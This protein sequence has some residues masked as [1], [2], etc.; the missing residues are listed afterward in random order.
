M[1]YHVKNPDRFRLIFG[2]FFLK[3]FN[4]AIRLNDHHYFLCL[5]VRF[6]N[7]TVFVFGEHPTKRGRCALMT[8]NANREETLI[9]ETDFRVLCPTVCINGEYIRLVIRSFLM[10]GFAT[11]T[12][13]PEQNISSMNTVSK[14]STVLTSLRMC[15]I[16]MFSGR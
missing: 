12:V 9:A 2:S 5:S 14:A 10:T 11:Y 15:R 1:C 7:N 13:L 6:S 3:M 4:T 8:F 16:V